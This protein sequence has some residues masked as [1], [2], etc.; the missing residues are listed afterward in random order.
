MKDGL[1]GISV[2]KRQPLRE[3][4]YESL[5]GAI[6][7]GKIRSGRRLIEEELASVVGASRTPV[8]EAVH[9]LEK[10]ELLIRLPN[11]GFVVRQFTIEDIE[12]I[13]GI[14]SVLESYAALLAT[15]HITDEMIR[16]LEKKIARS[17]ECAAD[18]DT[19]GIIRLNTEFHDILYKAAKS[20]KLYRMISNFRDYFYRYRVAILGV[21][22]MP[23][24]SIQ[25]HRDML[26][27]MKG[28]NARKAEK[29]V[30]RHIL[31]GKDIVI[32]QIKEGNLH[33]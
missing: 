15:R 19:N 31:R 6:L 20:G 5:K 22:G 1:G 12:E 18:K 33:L 17:V 25:D 26:A 11:G 2:S 7:G 9:K 29:L 27:A 4:V 30:K 3:E 24:V 10:D 21:D 23:D 28:K 14:R 16:L 13:F 8:R 32:Q